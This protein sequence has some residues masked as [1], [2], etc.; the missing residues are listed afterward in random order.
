[1]PALQA[2]K[3][4]TLSGSL[5]SFVDLIP[6]D[7]RRGK[8]SVAKIGLSKFVNYHFAHSASHIFNL[9]SQKYQSIKK[10]KKCF[11]RAS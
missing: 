10:D 6:G 3:P 9:S 8:R 1:L 11:V 2:P 5:T 7:R 4:T